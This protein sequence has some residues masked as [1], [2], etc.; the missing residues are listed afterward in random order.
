ML[1]C[2]LVHPHFIGLEPAAGAPAPARWIGTAG[3]LVDLCSLLANGLGSSTVAL[4]GRHEF[5]RAVV[6]PV[7]VP[8]NERHHPLT[9]LV[10]AGKGPAWVVGP[11]FDRSEQGF[12]VRVSLE[13][14]GREKDLSTPISSS[15]DSSVAPRISLPLSAWRISGGCWHWRLPKP[16]GRW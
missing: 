8:I 4:V 9:S 10:L 5:D 12:R 11:V 15:R 16:L 13:T 1:F 3:G 2:W 14:L 6:V 7:V